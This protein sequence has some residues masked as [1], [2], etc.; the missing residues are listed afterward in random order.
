MS[1]LAPA[2]AYA[3][4]APTYSA[5]TA[6]SALEASVVESLG[7]PLQGRR[8]L[9][10]GCGIARRLPTAREAGAAIV[11][12]MDLT[13]RMLAEASGE[14]LL[15]AADVRA[16]P[17]PDAAFDVVWCR[18]VL[19]HLP[20]LAPAY[21]ELARVC[22]PGGQVVVT[23]FHPTAAAAGHRRTFRD[24]DGALREV[25]HHV[26]SPRAHRRAAASAGLALEQQRD[27]VVSD[28]V[29]GYYERA[30]RMEAYERQRGLRVVL[31]LTFKRVA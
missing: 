4:W 27:R 23:D 29:R 11:V 30:G 15:A 19:G 12:G 8:L 2:D 14:T 31:A 25:E 21:A 7:V 9:D 24:A 1:A 20:D 26:H 22:A 13:P 10:I 6:I 5:E 28:R 18:L 16:I 3:L 17:A